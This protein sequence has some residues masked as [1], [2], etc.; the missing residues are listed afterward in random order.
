MGTVTFISKSSSISL[1]FNEEPKKEILEQNEKSMII[2]P[3]EISKTINKVND[4]IKLKMK[5][6]FQIVEKKGGWFGG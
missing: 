1:K 4:A 2:K 5:N 3:K 6:K